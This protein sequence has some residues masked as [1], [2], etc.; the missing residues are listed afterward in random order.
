M[1]DQPHRDYITR[2]GRHLVDH[3]HSAARSYSPKS[4]SLRSTRNYSPDRNGFEATKKSPV[5]QYVWA[6]A[7]ALLH[8]LN[9]DS[10]Q[11]FYHCRHVLELGAGTGYLGISLAKLGASQVVLTDLSHQCKL[12]NRNLELNACTGDVHVGALPWGTMA[13]TEMLA[14]HKLDL[15]VAADV[16]YNYDLLELL[17]ATTAGL[18]YDSDLVAPGACAVFALPRHRSHL[19]LPDHAHNLVYDLLQRRHGL[20]AALVG[21]VKDPAVE[22]GARYFSGAA[23]GEGSLPI[24]VFMIST[25]APAAFRGHA[26]GFGSMS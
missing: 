3:S 17:A 14:G 24:D 15:V 18:L 21:S 19:H 10:N 23:S 8:W 25:Q 26:R 20:H 9:A 13:N 2:L 5:V 11:R 7:P 12:I 4:L 6:A 16:A 22:L 1:S